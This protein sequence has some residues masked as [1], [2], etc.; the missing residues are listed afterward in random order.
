MVTVLAFVFV[1]SVLV[2][3]HEGGHFVAA[4][5]AGIRVLRFSFGF[6]KVLFRVKRRGTEYA[7]SLLPLGGY[8]KMAGGDEGESTGAPDE[9]MSKPPWVRMLVA[10]AG[11]AMNVLLAV[12]LYA[13]LA[14]VGYV[15]STY[16]NRVG[17][18]LETIS[19]EGKEMPAPARAAG[20]RPGDVI[21]AVNGAPTSYWY[22]LQK[23]VNDGVGKRLVFDI[24]RADG[25]AFVSAVPLLEPD[26][27][28]GL[29]GLVPYQAPV[30]SF[31]APKSK[32]AGA[33]VRPGDRLVILDGRPVVSFT[34]IIL[35]APKLAAGR[36]EVVFVSPAGLKKTARV[37]FRDGGADAFLSALGVDCGGVEVKV[38][39]SWVGAVPE[40]G[41]RTWEQVTATGRALGWM[42]KGRVKVTKTLGGPIT[43]ARVAGT[44]ARFGPVA[45][46][47]FIGYLSV[48]LGMVNL[49]PVPLLDGGHIVISLVETVRRR[50]L[51][52]RAREWV[53]VAGLVFII[54]LTALALFVDVNRLFH[55]EGF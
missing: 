32:A 50:R 42:V 39:A 8:V 22:E 10:A 15:V 25:R 6:G 36:H 21:V 24:R 9:F 13:A 28:R 12:V 17:G 40:G 35:G 55:R 54:G 7:V 30:V 53:T 38:S 48:M 29:V 34:E 3:A 27:G 49:L 14:K 26:T 5:L 51:S 43:I 46:L 31:V 1:L 4:K 47:S 18:V 23:A 2:F 37:D 45:F 16:P 52:A 41:R 11:P 44:A 33:G 20:F 19:V